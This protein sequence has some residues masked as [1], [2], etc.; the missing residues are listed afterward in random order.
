VNDA[1]DQVVWRQEEG[2]SDES[3]L[4]LNQVDRQVEALT[5]NP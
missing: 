5:V 4:D 1:E 2:L 3:P